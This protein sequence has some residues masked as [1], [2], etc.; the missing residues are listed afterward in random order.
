MNPAQLTVFLNNFSA[1]LTKQGGTLIT[2]LLPPLT[3]TSTFFLSYG[4]P[5]GTAYLPA[6]ALAQIGVGVVQTAT[7][8]NASTFTA[9]IAP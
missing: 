5:S 3:Q 6:V 4:I 7:S 2:P 9:S 8:N 1:L